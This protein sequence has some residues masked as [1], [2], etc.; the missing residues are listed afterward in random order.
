MLIVL[1]TSYWKVSAQ[2]LIKNNNDTLQPKIDM[3][4]VEN[5]TL[6]TI[7]RKFAEIIA[8]QYDSLQ[9]VTNKL[10]ECKDV[11]NTSLEVKDQYKIALE[12]SEGVSDMLKK[13][14]MTKDKVIKSYIKIEETQNKLIDNLN[15]EFRK[16]KTRNTILTGITIGGVTVGFTSLVLLLL[17]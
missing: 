8:I 2:D 14:L 13:E 6:F 12:K 16:L 15:G 7:N 17:K 10:N 3:V 11:L 1:M 9:I 5:D 4:V